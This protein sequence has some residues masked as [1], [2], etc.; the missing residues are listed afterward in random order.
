M[1]VQEATQGPVTTT[2]EVQPDNEA[3]QINHEHAERMDGAFLSIVFSAAIPCGLVVIVTAILL[4]VIY[5]KEVDPNRGWPELRLTSNTT[6]ASGLYM[7]L[8]DWK[9]LGGDPAVFVDFNPTSLTAIATL[10][11]KVIPYLSSSIMALVA[12]FVARRIILIS[13]E[14]EARD[15]LT[16]HQMSLL[17]QLLGGSSFTPLKDCVHYHVKHKKRWISPIP[18]AFSALA[19]V[20]ALGIIIPAADTWFATTVTPRTV[21]MLEKITNSSNSNFGRGLWNPNGTCYDYWAFNET[22]DG[23]PWPMPCNMNYLTYDQDIHDPRKWSYNV[24]NANEAML[25]M[26]GL[27]ET[28]IVRTYSDPENPNVQYKYLA[29]KMMNTTRDFRALTFAVKTECTPMTTKCFPWVS[30]D[31]S[32]DNWGSIGTNY[33]FQCSPGYV[34]ELTSNGASL[35]T[36]LRTTSNVSTGVGFAPDASLSRMIGNDASNVEFAAFT[37]PLYFGAWSLGWKNVPN[38]TDWGEWEYDE[39]IFYDDNY[40]YTWMLNCSTSLYAVNYDW[41]NGTV[42]TFNTSLSDADAG[43]PVSYPFAAGLPAADLCLDYA[44][45]RIQQA[46]NSSQLADWWGNFFSSCAM[47]MFSATLDA[48]ETDLEQ[49]RNNN[50]IATRVPIVPL[51]VLLGFKFLYCFAVLVLAVAAYH[52]TNPSESQ[53]VKERLSVKG[54]A[55]TCFGEGPSHQQVAVKNIE[56]LFQPPA[57]GAAGAADAT[58]RDANAEAEANPPP[59]QKVA[60]V[61]TEMGGWQFV[62]MAAGRV[63][64]TVAPIVERQVMS[65]ATGGTFGAGGQ[66]AA[67]WISLV[68]K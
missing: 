3:I 52:Y 54:L 34:G 20:T 57:A 36:G 25:T 38:G 31:Q 23:D 56:Q 67:K 17:I 30:V 19:A 29:D 53:S 28:N 16:P 45:A 9:N 11:G 7:I 8:S 40:Y 62:K 2:E 1:G 6:S 22:S 50:H 65:E 4:G 18:H 55:A 37:N 12:F 21:V 39:E 24:F 32:K 27:S 33:T 49:T 44:S 68:K 35:A 10:T 41:V 66:D 61:Q 43:G 60:M 64:D 58:N 14:D 5:A 13:K 47:Y 26:T 59:E 46:D 42:Q 51:F 15:L 48:H 63:Y